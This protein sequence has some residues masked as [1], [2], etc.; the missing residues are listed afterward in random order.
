MF[1]PD[2]PDKLETIY[3]RKYLGIIWSITLTPFS[4]LKWT[5]K[6]EETRLSN[7]KYIYI[8]HIG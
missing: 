1:V 5:E 8:Y 4:L 6:R 3:H 7:S 2:K